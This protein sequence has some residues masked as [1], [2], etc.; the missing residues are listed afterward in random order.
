MEYMSY[1]SKKKSE[2]ILLSWRKEN[3]LVMSQPLRN[4]RICEG[5]GQQLSLNLVITFPKGLPSRMKEAK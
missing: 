3:F 4:I 1:A 5:N 2:N